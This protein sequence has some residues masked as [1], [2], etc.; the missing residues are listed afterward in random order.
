MMSAFH[1]SLGLLATILFLPTALAA[2]GQPAA[3]ADG[4]LL[5]VDVEGGISQPLPIAVPVM[6]TPRSTPTPE[7]DTASLGRQVAEIVAGDLRSSGLFTPVGPS[8]LPSVSFAQVTAPSFDAWRPMNASALVQGFVQ[9]NADGNLT[10]GCYLYDVA[11]GTKLTRQG[12][13][14]APANWRRAAHKCADAVYGRLTGEGAYF[15]TRL[16]YV[17]ETG[18]K[19][20]RV[21]RIAVMDADGSNHRFLT[22]GTS[23]VLTPRFSPLGGQLVYMTYADKVPRAYVLD[24]ASGRQRPLVPGNAM[25]FAAR[26]SPDGRNILFSMAV[27][28][29]TDVYR[30]SADGGSPQRLTVA[31]G[32]DTGGSYSP[33]GSRI[34]FESDR[35]GTQ[36]LYVMGADGSNQRRISFG[37]GSY[38]TPV[39]SPR[40]DQIAFT[41]IGGG[42]F[43]IGVMTPSGSGEKLL[44]ESWQDEGPSW[45]PNGRVVMFHRTAQGSGKADLWSVDL[46]G[47]NE[48]RIPTPQDGSDPSWS[49]LL[50]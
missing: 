43:R 15:D 12:F 37:G 32:I 6:P 31:P 13:T 14:V 9:A 41:R 36:Q 11:A 26:Y 29:N 3:P 17:A 1:C 40:G 30:V 48:R 16:V 34:V 42:R 19:T 50:K 28:G 22:Q 38:A 21:K 4:E 35:G 44:T 24:L 49:P 5:E 2:Q 7:G 33:D 46:T 25:T 27:N 45:A 8:G 20:R 23:T 39:W 10:V 18:P 47:V